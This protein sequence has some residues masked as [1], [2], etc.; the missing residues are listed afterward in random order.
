MGFAE[1]RRETTADGDARRSFQPKDGLV[2]SETSALLLTDTGAAFAS[3][4]YT[5]SLAADAAAAAVKKPQPGE[6]ASDPSTGNGNGHPQAALKPTWDADRRQLH[7]GG[8]LVKWFRVPAASQEALLAAF[9]EESWPAHI[10][11]PLPGVPDGV[12]KQRLNS[13]IKRLNDCQTNRLIHFHGDGRG[14]GVRWT[15]IAKIGLNGKA[16]PTDRGN[17]HH[18]ESIHEPSRIRSPVS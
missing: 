5:T 14:E 3:R 10:D 9:E 1:H 18:T 15:L 12:P 11:D 7:V 4:I 13:A 2:F 8:Q 17:G 6:A 16:T